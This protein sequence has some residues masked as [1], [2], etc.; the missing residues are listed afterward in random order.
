FSEWSAPSYFDTALNLI[1]SQSR[2]AAENVM[3]A[4]GRM[5]AP[6]G[7]TFDFANS[8]LN[9]SV[10][11]SF[12]PLNKTTNIAPPGVCMYWF[13]TRV[14]SRYSG[15][16]VDTDGDLAVNV[17][18]TDVNHPPTFK[19]HAVL[20][21]WDETNVTWNNFVGP[22]WG[23]WAVKFGPELDANL[24]DATDTVYHWTVPKSLIQSWVN[25]T[26]LN[27]GVALI[28]LGQ[29]NTTFNTQRAAIP[30]KLTFDLSSTNAVP[31][32]QP[33]N[34]SPADGAT[35]LQLT[36]VLES[37][38]YS[39]GV[40]Q[41]AAQWQIAGD[42]GFSAPV[43]DVTSTSAFTQITVSS[44]VLQFS[45]RYYWRVRHVGVDGG[46]S[47]YSLPTKFD[48]EVKEG[49]FN[50]LALQS[51]M[52]LRSQPTSNYNGSVDTMFWPMPASNGICGIMMAWFDLSMFNGLTTES[53]AT[54]TVRNGFVDPN[55]GPITFNCYEL[56]KPWAENSATW[57]SYVGDGDYTEVL[58]ADLG[59]QTLP[60]ENL[61]STTW[62]IS[63]ALIQ[64]W[65]DSPETN[66]GVAIKPLTSNGNA[67][68]YT[69]RFAGTSPSLMVSV[70]P[71]PAVVALAALCAAA[72]FR[73]RN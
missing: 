10:V 24:M 29:G 53:N 56:L 17:L 14:F 3:I 59:A 55:F 16:N 19:L 70:V 54:F 51:A 27:L 13:D 33:A 26:N 4:P 7:H 62:V 71:E 8:N 32:A 38:A 69:R 18:Y 66:F 1:Q 65:L 9:G 48:T 72:M 15:L 50:K 6:A 47:A 11:S 37:T 12:N 64:K 43:W 46:K 45:S 23:T 52:I 68:I 28:P 5:D 42:P 49:T 36:P 2:I 25:D 61:S 44:N 67:Y 40:P 21:G 31:P 34:A 41:G 35:G 20:Q 73:K 22:D 60:L 57:A 30:P 39:G 63:Q 58:G